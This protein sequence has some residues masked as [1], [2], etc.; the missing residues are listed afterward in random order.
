MTARCKPEAGANAACRSVFVVLQAAQDDAGPSV[1]DPQLPE[2]ADSLR[3]LAYEVTVAEARER[4]RV[5]QGLHDDIGQSLALIMLKLG[6][7]G[8]SVASQPVAQRVDEVKALVL[9]TARAARSATFELSCPVLQQLGLQAAIESLGQR[10]QRL[11]ALN[12]QVEL[13]LPHGILPHA[14][15]VVIFRVVRE[16]LCNVQK[17]AGTAS[18]SVRSRHHDGRVTLV[19]RDDGEGFDVRGRPRRFGPEG[20]F[21]LFSAQAQMRAIGGRLDVDSCRGRG[22]CATLSVPVP[23]D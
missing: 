21:G 18:A 19:V 3:A 9:Q 15:N 5:A 7:L 20:G 23:A 22:T 14:M 4:E 12:V 2:S 10:M 17:H 13:D 11:F 8:E 16:L 1:G 6:E